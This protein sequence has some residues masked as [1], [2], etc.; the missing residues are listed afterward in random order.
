MIVNENVAI[1]VN[2]KDLFDEPTSNIQT[3][4]DH[5]INYKKRLTGL[6]SCN[7]TKIGCLSQMNQVK[8]SIDRPA[9]GTRK[10]YFKS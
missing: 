4:L 9:S 10:R 3:G 7:L 2:Q 6:N 8:E 1:I 5:V